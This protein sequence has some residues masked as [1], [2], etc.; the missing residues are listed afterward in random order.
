MSLCIP[1]YYVKTFP[2]QGWIVGGV[3]F[4]AVRVVSKES[5]RL[6]LHKFL[7]YSFFLCFLPSE[8]QFDGQIWLWSTTTTFIV[9]RTLTSFDSTIAIRAAPSRR[10]PLRRARCITDS[11]ISIRVPP[12]GHLEHFRACA[13]T[14]GTYR[15]SLRRHLAVPD[16]V[17]LGS[18]SVEN[19]SP[20]FLLLTSKE[21]SYSICINN[22][23]VSSNKISQSGLQWYRIKNNSLGLHVSYL[24]LNL[25]LP[26]NKLLSAWALLSCGMLIGLLL[27]R[28]IICEVPIRWDAEG[29]S[30]PV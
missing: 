28:C 26:F 8:V 18:V 30:R 14:Y 12:P 27:K 2:W 5:R 10:I 7:V 4:H 19:M 3:A 22:C 25:K 1:V 21:I 13:G 17:T 6:V 15:F 9:S 11:V 20:C 29:K 16:A 24:H 23:S